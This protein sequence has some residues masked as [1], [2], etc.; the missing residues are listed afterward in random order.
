VLRAPHAGVV[1]MAR[2]TA[3]VLRGDGAYMIATPQVT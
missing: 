2:R 3:R 1:V